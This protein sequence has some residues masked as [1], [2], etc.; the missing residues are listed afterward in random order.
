MSEITKK[1]RN[2]VILLIL[3]TLVSCLIIAYYWSNSSLSSISLVPISIM[4]LALLY[5]L[6]QMAKRFF[7]K[8]Q[9]W[10]DWLY[11]VGLLSMITPTFFANNSN[12]YIFHLVTD[13]GILFLLIPILFDGKSLLNGNRK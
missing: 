4:A 9:N 1:K 6:I 10:W 5:I 13:Y 3:S 7:V 12:E 8:E 2:K 11:Y